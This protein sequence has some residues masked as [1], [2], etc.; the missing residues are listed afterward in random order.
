MLHLEGDNGR[1]RSIIA[2]LQK[3]VYCCLYLRFIKDGSLFLI[4]LGW[5]ISSLCDFI[6]ELTLRCLKKNYLEVRH[7]NDQEDDESL[8]IR[9]LETPIVR[10][11]INKAIRYYQGLI[12]LE[13]AYCIMYHI[14]LDVTRDIC[15][16]PYG[17]VIMLLIREFTCP[18]PAG[19]PSK[20]LL[21]VLDIVLLFSQIIIMNGSLSSSFQNVKLIV[22]ELNAEEEGALNILKLNTWRMN[23]SGPELIVRKNHDNIFPQQIDEDDATEFTPLLNSAE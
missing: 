20:L 9:G 17:F 15:S 2:N 5:I 14:R 1:Q 16:K 4:L 10:M 13:T 22:K 3:F 11:I 21:V 23:A 6:Q 8:A 12:L 19:Y 7:D 18:T